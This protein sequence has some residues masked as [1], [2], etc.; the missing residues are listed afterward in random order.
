MAGN[1][2]GSAAVGLS[3][4]TRARLS[5][6]VEF[7]RSML[8]M[9]GGLK[10]MACTPEMCDPEF[11]QKITAKLTVLKLPTEHEGNHQLMEVVLTP[12]KAK[13]GETVKVSVRVAKE[14]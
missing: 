8:T 5:L 4:S 12:K 7:G 6:W 9:T 1:P 2:S 11:T 3:F 14:S 13:P 10:Y